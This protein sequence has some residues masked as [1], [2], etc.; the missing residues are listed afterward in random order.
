[1]GSEQISL[2]LKDLNRSIGSKKKNMEQ[3]FSWAI[4]Q[5]ANF[6]VNNES[7]PIQNIFNEMESLYKE[8]MMYNHNT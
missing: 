7:F 1:M 4:S 2:V 6:Q 3:F 5:S 8:L